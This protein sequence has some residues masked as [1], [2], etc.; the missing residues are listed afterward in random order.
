MKQI[1][2]YFRFY[3]YI[4]LLFLY[5][6][7]VITQSKDSRKAITNRSCR[8]YMYTNVL[9]ACVLG[10]FLKCQRF[11]LDGFASKINLILGSSRHIDKQIKRE[12]D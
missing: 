8:F 6:A 1:S 4:K 9:I 10:I 12:L 7:V 11:K 2:K 3:K 5:S